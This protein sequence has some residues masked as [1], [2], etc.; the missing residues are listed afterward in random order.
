MEKR[1]DKK[2]MGMLGAAST[3]ALLAGGS[4]SAATSGTEPAGVA[5]ANSFAELL[6]P[7]PNAVDVLKVDNEN[8][9]SEPAQAPEQVAQY[10]HHH[11]HHYY[12]HHHHH[13]YHHHHWYHHHHHHHYW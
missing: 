1:M 2:L 12:H 7:I 10:H 13:Y 6:D 4:A 11:H 5:P 9:A 8:R 3:L